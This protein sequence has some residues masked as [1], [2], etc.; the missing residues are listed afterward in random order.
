MTADE[1]NNKHNHGIA[2]GASRQSLFGAS[3]HRLVISLLGVNE[4]G[5]PTQ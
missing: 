4:N 5:T 3:E 1:S 2:G